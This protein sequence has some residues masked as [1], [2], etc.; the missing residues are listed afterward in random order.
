[1]PASFVAEKIVLPNGAIEPRY[2]APR[3]VETGKVPV[4]R[5]YDAAAAIRAIPRH[6]QLLLNLLIDKK[7]RFSAADNCGLPAHFVLYTGN[8]PGFGRTSCRFFAN[9]LRSNHRGSEKSSAMADGAKPQ[10][11]R[12]GR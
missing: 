2:Y 9:F 5:Q 4:S 6:P 8:I 10:A 12:V 3:V 1:M 7:F 11:I